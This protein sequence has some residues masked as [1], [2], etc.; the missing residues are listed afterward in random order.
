MKLILLSGGSGKRLWPLSNDARSKQFLKVLSH[1]TRNEKESMVQRVWRQ[2]DEQ[3]LQSSA[4]IATSQSQEDMIY[5]QLGLDVPLIIEPERKDTF[6]AIAL[7]AVYLYAVEKVP[8]HEVVTVMPVDPYTEEVF[9]QKIHELEHIILH[10]NAQ[11]AL[12]GVKPLHPSEKYGYIIPE[13]KRESVEGTTYHTVQRFSE[14]PNKAM[15]ETLMTEG[16]LW[17]CGV[18][19]FKLEYFISLL[20]EKGI[21]IDYETLVKQYTHLNKISFDYE[22]V[23]KAEHIVVT[24]YEG[25]WKDLGTWNTLTEE[26]SHHTTGKA[27]MTENSQNTHII[28]ELD[29][30]VTV[31][32]CSDM[33]VA[34]SADGILVTDKAQSPQIKQ[35]IEHIEQR[36]MYEESRWGWQKVLDVTKDQFGNEVLTTRMCIKQGCNI[37][38]QRDE[39]HNEVWTII[40]GEGKFILDGEASYV[41][42][43][44]VLHIPADAAHTILAKKEIECIA[45]KYGM[46]PTQKDTTYPIIAMTK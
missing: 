31:I 17:N 9:F 10:S 26:M 22:V 12:M 15:A 40:S 32:G 1:P 19:S 21:P 2:L 37:S 39:K 36:P 28:N 11:L 5:N 24:P 43:G 38:Y 4:Y 44:D 42:A 30:P 3:G 16:A 14:K 27:V 7:S 25:D 20:V 34:A 29:I 33:V 45:V 6:P 41:S 18:F 23:E 46:R 8:L 13:N 35:V